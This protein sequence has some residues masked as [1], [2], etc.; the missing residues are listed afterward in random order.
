MNGRGPFDR[1]QF[2]NKQSFHKKI[3]AKSFV[4]ADSVNFKRHRLLPFN[5]KAASSN[6]FGKDSLVNGFK[7]TG[8]EAPMEMIPTVDGHCRNDFDVSHPFLPSLRAFAPS[9]E[10]NP[11]ID[12]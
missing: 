6:L 12:M 9:R 7:K 8:S 10:S 11:P 1:F 3:D 5:G 4:E 2:D